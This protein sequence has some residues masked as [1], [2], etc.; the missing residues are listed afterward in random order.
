MP[1]SAEDRLAIMDL[2]A[3]YNHCLDGGDPAGW[4]DCFTEDG[5]FESSRSGRS[6][7]RQQLVAFAE[8]VA[9]NRAGIRHFIDNLVIDG[10]GDRATLRCYLLL[11]D[12]REVPP[13]AA[14]F[15]RYD[16]ELTR[17]PA[18]WRFRHRRVG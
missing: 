2:A 8:D 4:A 1:L 18:G 6:E 10:D 17:T 7:G 14:A 9:A 5:V 3:R 13:R 15:A 11:W 16:D 12:C